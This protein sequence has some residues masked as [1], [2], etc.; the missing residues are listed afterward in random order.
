MPVKE[1]KPFWGNRLMKEPSV[2]NISFCAGRDVQA[3]PMA[4]EILIPYDLWTNYAHCQMLHKQNILKNKEWTQLSRAFRA[5]YL[6][7]QKG[8]FILNAALEDVH[9]NIENYL[10]HQKNITVAKK[11]HT[12][13]SRNDQVATTIRLYMRE[14]LLVFM[15]ESILLVEEILLLCEKEKNTPMIGFTHYQP[16]MPTTFA[17]WVAHWSQSIIRSLFDMLQVVIQMNFSPLGAVAGFGTTWNIDREY[18]AKLLGFDGVEQNSLD[19]ISSRGE[20][21]ARI[22][23]SLAL[24]ANQTCMIAQD[25]IMLAHPYFGMI[26]IDDSLVTGSSIMPQK[27]NPDFAEVIRAKCSFCHGSLQSLLGLGKG[28][29]SGYNRDSQQSKYLIL[30]LFSEMHKVP[31]ILQ[32]VLKN[33]QP[34][35]QRMKELS[36]QNYAISTDLVDY[37]AANSM[38][39][40]RDSYHLVSLAIKF[41]KEKITFQNLQKAAKQL[42][43]DFPWEEKQ[44]QAILHNEDVMKL[45]AQKKH[46]GAPSPQ[47]VQKNI[48]YQKKELAN[49]KKKINSTFQ[50]IQKARFQCFPK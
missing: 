25:L 35:R 13:R 42:Q 46:T 23:S 10:F 36:T 27:R 47:A 26:K 8:D 24:F 15:K 3:M 33:I 37:L 6:S 5:L 17:H 18:A 22:A 9:T 21:E 48:S 30:D 20:W 41:S 29:M 19:T 49:Y 34:C 16:A 44:L 43:L 7:Y 2:E 28:I 45:L 31:K 4:D 39:A 12:A 40:F 11:I 38:I 50:K 32:I 14:Q 1:K